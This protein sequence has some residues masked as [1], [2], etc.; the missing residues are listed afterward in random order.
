M[1]LRVTPVTSRSFCWA[2]AASLIVHG[3]ILFVPWTWP[4]RVEQPSGR[5]SA[6]LVRRD[7]TPAPNA[8]QAALPHSIPLARPPATPRVLA[9]KQPAAR[10]VTPEPKWSAAEKAD[11]DKFLRELDDQARARPRPSLAQR[12]LAMA[13]EIGRQQIRQGETEN[14]L[15]QRVPNGPPVDPFSLEMY[16]D[17]MV[18]KLNR[19][20]AFVRND[21][22]KMGMKSAAVR[23][24]LNPDGSLESFAVLNAADQQDAIAYIRSVVERAVPF[25]AFP[26]DLRASALSL[27]LLI[28]IHPAN[29]DEGSGFSRMASGTVC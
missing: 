18:K 24:R 14:E 10:S 17:A 2:I 9:L 8:V 28:C 12:S 3:I 22:R 23:V 1:C 20:S 15:V 29:L 21:P 19:S 4:P 5:F 6:T 11:M 27:G 16:L 25:S 13:H 7:P 26:P